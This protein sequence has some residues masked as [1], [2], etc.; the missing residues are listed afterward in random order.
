MD[1]VAGCG[2]LTGDDGGGVGMKR[3]DNLEGTSLENKPAL[4]AGVFGVS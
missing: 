1:G 3:F 2:G 4:R